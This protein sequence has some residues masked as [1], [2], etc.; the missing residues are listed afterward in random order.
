MRNEALGI[1]DLVVAFGGVAAVD[2][3]SISIERG[4]VLA[5]VGPNGAGKTTV[6][7]AV[8]GIAPV[9]EGAIWFDDRKVD[10]RHVAGHHRP[11]LGIARTFQE[12][13]LVPGLSVGDQLLCGVLPRA[14]LSTL[15]SAVRTP[16]FLKSERSQ[17]DRAQLLLHDLG[18]GNTWA[19]LVDSLPAGHR[20]LVDLG[21]ALMSQPK[22][23]LL[24]EIA[25]G[26]SDEEKAQTIAFVR[27][28]QNEQ[29]V[30]VLFI[31][32]DLEVVRKLA[33]RVVVMAMG[34]VLAEGSAADALSRA[35]VL[36]AY[37]GSRV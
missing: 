18:I 9:R 36:E 32:H 3:A 15:A 24:D 30:T 37:V 20:R 14:R 29:G 19:R 13:R 27:R 25:A 11:E 23:L 31:E 5:V 7:N 26:L 33:D 35:D 8:S 4:E 2:R 16:H 28:L 34:S 17:A 10:L 1:V 6:L 12:S 21:R 22:L